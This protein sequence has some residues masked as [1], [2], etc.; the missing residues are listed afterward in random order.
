MSISPILQFLPRLLIACVLTMMIGSPVFA[1]WNEGKAAADAGDYQ[2]AYEEF[3]PLAEQGHVSA[4][5]ML[6][7]MYFSGQGVPQDFV[8]AHMWLNIASANG[9]DKASEVRDTVA[10]K[11]TSQD[12]STAQAMARECVG[13]N[14]QNCGY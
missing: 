12:I 10:Q 14:Y 1:G 9:D 8:V 11:M 7:V 5:T 3:L 13:S 4:Q 6:G 2:T